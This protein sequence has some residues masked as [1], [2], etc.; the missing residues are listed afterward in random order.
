[1]RKIAASIITVCAIICFLPA[2]AMGM[3]IWI[4]FWPLATVVM[5]WVWAADS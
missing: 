5:S 3:P 1:M 2:A 4:L